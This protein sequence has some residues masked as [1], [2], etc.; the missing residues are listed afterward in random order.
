MQGDLVFL[1]TETTSLD[2]TKGQ[3]WELAVVH[4]QPTMV[5]FMSEPGI[6]PYTDDESV[7]Q[8]RPD[9]GRADAE[10]LRIGRFEE[11]FMVPEGANAAMIDPGAGELCWRGPLHEALF[12]IQQP[13]HGATIVAAQPAFDAAFLKALLRHFSRRIGWHYRLMCVESMTAGRLGWTKARGLRDCADALG[14]KYDDAA[15]HTA[16]GDARL[17]RDVFDAITGGSS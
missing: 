11:R 5:G 16:L 9:L 7:W 1:D 2:E 4:R 17:V 13:L 15:L 6:L 14:V 12:D 8:L 3:I 10:A